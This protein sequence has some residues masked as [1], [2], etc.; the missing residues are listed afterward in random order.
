MHQE[1]QKELLL[2]CRHLVVQMLNVNCI[3]IFLPA[4]VYPHLL[5]PR[6]IVDRNV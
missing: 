4:L 2:A 1:Q 6:R 3:M 5:V